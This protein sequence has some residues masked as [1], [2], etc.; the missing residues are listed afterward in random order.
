MT[1]EEANDLLATFQ[2][3]GLVA[4]ALIE[5]SQARETCWF[6]L[7]RLCGRPIREF[8][9]DADP[10]EDPGL[11][12]QAIQAL[13]AIREDGIWI[14]RIQDGKGVPTEGRWQ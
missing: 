14:R 6:R 13:E 3:L 9:L 7:E 12:L 11:Y 1:R 2:V 5:D 4:G 8:L 10:E